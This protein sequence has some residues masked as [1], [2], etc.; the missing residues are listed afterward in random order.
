M[1]YPKRCS[2]VFIFFFIVLHTVY[3]QPRLML[4]LGHTESISDAGFSADG[5]YLATAS[6][7]G[8]MLWETATG[9][10]L[11]TLKGNAVG[12]FIHNG[13]SIVSYLHDSDSTGNINIT[14]LRSSVVT[15][16][17]DGYSINFN[18][19][20]EYALIA[21]SNNI[22][23]YW[24]YKTKKT[25]FKLRGIFASFI[26]N[27]KYILTA[28]EKGREQYIFKIWDIASRQLLHT[29][30]GELSGY[31]EK[32]ICLSEGDK[33][34]II[35][36]LTGD[37]T[38][39]FSI[40][41]KM[42]GGDSIY[43]SYRVR[44]DR[45]KKLMAVW[46]RYH[47]GFAFIFDTEHF[48]IKKQFYFSKDISDVIFKGSTAILVTDEDSS[49]VALSIAT[50]DTLYTLKGHSDYIR[51]LQYSPDKKYILTIAADAKA[52]LWNAATGAKQKVFEGKN[53]MPIQSATS[54][55]GNFFSC[56]L[57]N[58]LMVYETAT[59]TKILS[60]PMEEGNISFSPDGK[61]VLVNRNVFSSDGY[62]FLKRIDINS[63]QLS[64]DF[65][66]KKDSGSYYFT[67]DGAIVAIPKEKQQAIEL[68]ADTGKLLNKIKHEENYEVERA[69][70]SE[71]KKY[72]IVL[73]IAN[74]GK[75]NEYY[76]MVSYTNGN[77]NINWTYKSKFINDDF[78]INEIKGELVIRTGYADNGF[79]YLNM[80]GG[81]QTLAAATD[82]GLGAGFYS[83]KVIF[84]SY[85]GK[86]LVFKDYKIIRFFDFAS[87]KL[88]LKVP[89]DRV[90]F[91]QFI[92]DNNVLL[93]NWNGKVDLWELDKKENTGGIEI[94][95]TIKAT[96]GLKY[97][98][99][100]RYYMYLYNL[101][102]EK[103]CSFINLGVDDYVTMIE[104][105]YYQSTQGASKQLYY[106]TNGLKTISFEQLDVKYN[107]PDKVLQAIGNTDTVLINSYRRAWEKRIKK[108]GIDT[109]SFRDGYSVPD[110]DIVNREAITVEQKRDKLLLHIKASDST[111]KLARFNIWV[112]ETPLFGQKGRSIQKRN[113]NSFD[114]TITINLSQG[115]NKI[116]T[117]V[118]NINGTESYRMP[119]TVNFT[120]VIKQKETLRFIG[121]GIDKF[122]DSQYNL[123][124]SSKD[125]RDLARKLKEKYKGN[126]IIDTLFN[127][128]VTV[129]AVKALKQKLLQTTVNDKVI[130]AY[131]GHGMLSKD[132]DYYL[133]TYAV[134]F[135]NPE[136]KGLAYEELENLLDSIPARKKLMLIDA[137][138]SGEVDKED[139]TTLEASSDSL[140]KGLKP[141]AYK[142]EGRV[143][144]KNSFELM[145]SLF[146]NVGKS[147][148]ATIIS[149]A[150]G[151]QFALEKNELKN[152]VFTYSIL[153]AMN[154][155]PSLT[156][157]ELKKIVG[158]RVEE[159]TKGLQ[160]PTSRNETIAVDWRIW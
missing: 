102:F 108:L 54:E 140:I 45:D 112:N 50:G 157:S 82:E 124:Y 56:F 65:N 62:P 4:P 125:I 83:E 58:N 81:K 121:I 20:E 86:V 72:F 105:G 115:E 29:Y 47:S 142:K 148:G 76:E 37:T 79:C 159:L 10:L 97:L 26:N 107:R 36:T 52:I 122:S 117:S 6:E 49:A 46:E 88:L 61:F 64:Y 32:Y 149:A 144:L 55:D 152:G 18:A 59:F 5:K 53:A 30:T 146:V 1:M 57:N 21:A 43:L 35:E 31:S 131:S 42:V 14:D 155:F 156:I 66:F 98:S 145:K 84:F 147:T 40:Q 119:L 34:A 143:G 3:A 96:T 99:A 69:I 67:N 158:A 75:D 11:Q 128:K 87:G 2:I 8:V 111:Y 139:L 134:D 19:S 78:E 118:T 109:T 12:G 68:Y 44:F 27:D 48:K 92:N 110:A 74:K 16:S 113:T 7:G 51:N 133:S 114:T 9:R 90:I 89:N 100:D 132:Y 73:Y 150:A 101:Y 135:E 104:G 123:L 24:D 137:C 116:E 91:I 28:E 15:D 94:S 130:V 95:G 80:A 154:K 60:V 136:Q 39:V 71:D 106:V 138:H 103:M 77:G 120:P 141:V 151:T 33:M 126:I 41:K 127:E 153:E 23:R 160:K 22:I 129:A 63:G 17:L 93:C 85:T 25:V 38:Q 13:S 70:F